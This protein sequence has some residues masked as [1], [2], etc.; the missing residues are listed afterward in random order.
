MVSVNRG[1]NVDESMMF[2]FLRQLERYFKKKLSKISSN[3]YSFKAYF[4]DITVYN[5]KELSDFYFKNATFGFPKILVAAC[6][7]LSMA[8]LESMTYLENS[9]GL[10]DKMFPLKSSHTSISNE[11]KRGA[12]QKDDGDLSPEGEKTRV[13]DG[14]NK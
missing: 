1:I 12:P 6:M 4:P 3:Q 2:G 7:G 5:R 13:T 8:D 10:V 11:D 14:N 9:L